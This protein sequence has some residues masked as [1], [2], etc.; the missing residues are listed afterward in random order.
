MKQT[1]TRE[2]R[3]RRADKATARKVNAP[4]P[5]K[6]Q[7]VVYQTL[8]SFQRAARRMEP[9]RQHRAAIWECMLGTVYA[10]NAAGE[11][12]YFDYDFEKAL[13]HVGAVTDVRVSRFMAYRTRIGSNGQADSYTLPRHG[14]RVWFVKDGGQE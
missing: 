1:A 8:G 3:I 13:A 6:A 4:E 7:P 10:M 11:V 12:E 2:N 5:V 14:Q 9:T